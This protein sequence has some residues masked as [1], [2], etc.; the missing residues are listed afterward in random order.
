MY[1]YYL[2][3]SL[4]APADYESTVST[5]TFTPDIGSVTVPVVIFNDT[6]VEGGET[7]FGN[8]EDIGQPVILAPQIATVLIT[9][10]ESDSKYRIEVS[11][12]KYGHTHDMYMRMY[13]CACID[14]VPNVR[15]YVFVQLAKSIMSPVSTNILDW[16]FE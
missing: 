11:L 1:V 5:L 6:I 13:M 2:S 12:K 7:F 10:D 3:L 9:E 14:L 4:A 8:L 16:A 15:T